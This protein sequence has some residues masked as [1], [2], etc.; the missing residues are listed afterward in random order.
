MKIIHSVLIISVIINI[1]FCKVGTNKLKDDSLAH[2]LAK[3]GGFYLPDNAVRH[4]QHNI[5]F[6]ATYILKFNNMINSNRVI[7]FHNT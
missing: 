3:N 2:G 6:I 4:I 1:T 5:L 7:L